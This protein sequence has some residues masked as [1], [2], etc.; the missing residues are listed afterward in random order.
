MPVRLRLT[1][2]LAVVA[3]LPSVARGDT[4]SYRQP[5]Q[6]IADVYHAPAL[7]ATIVSP[8]HDTLAVVTPL[9]Y[10]PIAD[11]ARPMLRIAGLRVDPATNGPH[12]AVAF[13]SLALVR[14]ANGEST[15]VGLPPNARVTAMRFSP[16]GAHFALANATPDGT[17]L[18][19]GT[20][21]TAALVRAPGV[22]LNGLFGDPFAWMPGGTHSSSA[23]SRAPARRRMRPSSRVDR[24]C[25]KPA[26]KRAKS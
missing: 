22:K 8:T 12:H 20:T 15:T 5:P 26:A 16:D 1:A 23:P 3:L 10:P 21:A 18:Y 11:L 19:L 13:T 6:A 25:K 7:P 17:D 4:I 24:S 9:R 14:V 2:A